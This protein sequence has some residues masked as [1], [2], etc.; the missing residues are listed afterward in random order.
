MAQHQIPSLSGI[1]QSD[2]AGTPN[3]VAERDA[4]G[5]LA[6]QRLRASAGV[7]NSGEV[8]AGIAAKSAS[9]NADSSQATV[10][11][12][13]TAADVTVT[14]PA[15]ATCTG[16]KLTFVKKVAANSMVIDGNAAETINGATTQTYASQ[17]D[18]VTVQSDGSNWWI[19]G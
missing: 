13:T 19:V 3:S 11:I 1:L 4:A 14:L 10:V 17:Y 12:D 2:S 8:Y 15:A 5:D 18:K 6:G 16:K 9:F 7:V